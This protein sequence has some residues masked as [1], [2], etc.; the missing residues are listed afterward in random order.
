MTGAEAVAPVVVMVMR[1]EGRPDEPPQDRGIAEI[2]R[3]HL[4]NRGIVVDNEDP[5]MLGR[6]QVSVPQVLGEFAAMQPELA[7]QIRQCEALSWQPIV[8]IYLLYT[9]SPF[10]P[11]MPPIVMLDYDPAAGDF[12]Q[13]AFD[14]ARL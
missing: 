6:I 13:W 14:R 2:V 11:D 5:L 4:A 3:D 1:M 8:T 7:V 10:T 12:G 9:D